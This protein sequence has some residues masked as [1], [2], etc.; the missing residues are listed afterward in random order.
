MRHRIKKGQISLFDTPEAHK[1]R[2]L[3][4]SLDLMR[5]LQ[6]MTGGASKQFYQKKVEALEIQLGQDKDQWEDPWVRRCLARRI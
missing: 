3:Q 5:A 4:N 2:K 6:N 1:I